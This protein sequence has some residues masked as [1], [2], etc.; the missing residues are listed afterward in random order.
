LETKIIG[1]ITIV[2]IVAIAGALALSHGGGNTTTTTNQPGV[3][4]TTTQ[5]SSVSIEGTWQGT[6]KGAQ[7][8]GE[9]KWVIKK[10]GA[11]S[12]TGCLQTSGTY[13]SNGGW[14]PITVTLDGN[15][16]EI[17][18][19]G[20]NAVLFSGTISGNTASG[21]WHFS[22]NYDSG[23]WQGTKVSS[24]TELLCTEQ[25]TQSQTAT[26]QS[27]TSTTSETTTTSTQTQTGIPMCTIQPPS[28]LKDYNDGVMEVVANVFGAN[29]LYCNAAAIEDG[30]YSEVYTVTNLDPSQI[31]NYVTQL[32]NGLQAKGWTN[33]SVTANVAGWGIYALKSSNNQTVELVL[34]M[35]MQ[36][37]TGNLAIHLEPS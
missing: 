28:N 22:T 14:M 36:G 25:T 27:T 18:S 30:T 9:W 10:T 31:N 7:G 17:G 21:T 4:T 37:T 19:V 34:L 26:S 16:I 1:I 6:Y 15:K 5:G 32:T 3:T 23:S 24:N 29:N 8:S 11:N 12:Y 35:Q 20:P 2:V 13:A 33:I